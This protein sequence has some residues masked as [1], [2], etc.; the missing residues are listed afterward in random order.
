LEVPTVPPAGRVI[1][2]TTYAG[3]DAEELP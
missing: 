1:P 3:D 2:R